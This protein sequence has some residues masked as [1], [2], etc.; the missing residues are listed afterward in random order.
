MACVSGETNARQPLPSMGPLLLGVAAFF[1]TAPALAQDGPDADYMRLRTVAI[2]VRYHDGQDWKAAPKR[3]GSGFLIH[4]DGYVL[5][6]RHLAPEEY[7]NDVEQRRKVKIYGQI[8]GRSSAE[9][10]LKIIDVHPAR[11]AMLLKFDRGSDSESLNFFAATNSFTLPIVQ[12]L[13]AGFPAAEGGTLKVV[14]Q[15]MRS[16]LGEGDLRGEVNARLPDGFSGGPVLRSREVVGVVESSSTEGQ[17][18]TF[19]FVPIRS[20]RSWLSDYVILDRFP[21]ASNYGDWSLVSPP[22]AFFR[23]LQ[24]D[25]RDPKVLFAGLDHGQGVYRSSDGGRSWERKGAGLGDSEVRAIAAS[26]FDER[27]Y[28]ATRNGLWV[29]QD[30]GLTWLEDSDFRGKSLLSVATS[31]HNRGLFLVGPQSPGGTYGG[32]GALFS[33]RMVVPAAGTEGAGLKFT[34]DGGRSWASLPIPES[35]NDIWIDPE[36]SRLFAIAAAD[37]GVFYTD[38]G[39]ENLR[40]LA[41]F[42]TKHQPLCLAVLHGDNT[43]RLLVGTI[44]DGLYWSDDV[45]RTWSRAEGIP[46]VQ[47]SDI[48]PGL[49][50]PSRVAAATMAGVFESRDGGTHWQSVS[51]GLAYTWCTKLERLSDG[52]LIVGTSGGGAYRRGPDQYTWNPSSDGFPPAVATRLIGAGGWVFAGSFVGLLKGPDEGGSW[53]FAGL[54]GEPVS[55][56]AVA[57]EAMD[58]PPPPAAESGLFVVRAGQG[59]PRVV[60]PRDHVPFDIVVGTFRG[61]LFRS[62]DTGASWAALPAPNRDHYPGAIRSITISRSTP[63][64]IGAVAEREGFFLS[65]DDGRTWSAGASEPVGKA[66]NLVAAAPENDKVLVALTVDRGVLR[67][68][69]TGSNWAK[70]EGIPAEETVT[71]IEWLH[72]ASAQVVFAATLRGVVY[73]S[74]DGGRT[75]ARISQVP[76][77]ASITAPDKLRW[78]TLA[79]LPGPKSAAKMILGSAVG[80]FLSHDGGK[81]WSPLHVGDIKNNYWVNDL[82]VDSERTLIMATNKGIF[83]RTFPLGP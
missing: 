16:P 26:P 29:S 47:V 50:S 31:P 24:A 53:Q 59:H 1:V 49:G 18:E 38:D 83:S 8:G 32:G 63:R 43:V 13:A 2:S 73:R 6:A 54:A 21:R 62:R 81:T 71:A 11:D 56:I 77:L 79:L 3:L 9:M 42:P 5:T 65:D 27:L 67:S 60:A 68:G 52:S 39:V 22:W 46:S 41:A 4:P 33:G 40:P 72:G 37:E 7:I 48:T 57:P 25:P 28:A 61:A 23:G 10:R 20:L 15:F 34:R 76:F 80:A 45:G 35:V 78:T 55:A 69:D 74:G 12:V 64:R 51:K 19:N 70:S 44:H 17:R 14:T 58:A 30:R 82:L 75:F 66:V 36:D